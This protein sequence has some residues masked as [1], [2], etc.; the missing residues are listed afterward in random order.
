MLKLQSYFSNQESRD[1]ALGIL[2][3]EFPQICFEIYDSGLYGS[4]IEFRAG[5]AT[6]G[7]IT[8]FIKDKFA[9]IFVCLA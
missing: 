9:S 2:E 6:C 4:G 7:Q 8:R 1:Y 5:F 3:A